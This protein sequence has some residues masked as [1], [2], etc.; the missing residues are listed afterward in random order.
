M[1]ITVYKSEIPVFAYEEMIHRIIRRNYPLLR[2]LHLDMEDVYQDLTIAAIRA[3]RMFDPNRSDSLEAHVW[4]QLQYAVLDMKQNYHPAGLTGLSGARP[5]VTS[6]EYCEEH[7]VQLAAPEDEE[8]ISGLRLRRA[9]SRLA[10]QERQ[11]VLLYL[12]DKRP[13]R[14]QQTALS[15]AFQKLREFYLSQPAFY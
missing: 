6:L 15:S 1:K 10:P 7:G 3:A 11:V 14:G 5:Y 4:M 12:E 8:D 2:A 13:R 9:L